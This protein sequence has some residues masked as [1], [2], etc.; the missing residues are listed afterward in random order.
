MNNKPN[1]LIFATK[2]GLAPKG[3]PSAVCYYY[4]QELDK[5]GTQDFSFIPSTEKKQN[6]NLHDLE[7]RYLSKLPEWL[8]GL[9]N[10]LKAIVKYNKMLGGKYPISEFDYAGYDIVHF[11]DVRQLYTRRYELENYKGIV[12]L[13]SHTPQPTGHELFNS[14]P[15]KIRFFIPNLRNRLKEMDRYA[16]E[17]ADYI[18]FP[19]PDA[20]EPYYNDWPEYKEIHDRKIRRYKYVL[21]GIPASTPKRSRNEVFN[22]LS[23]PKENFVISYVGRHNEVKGYDNLKQIGSKFLNANNNTWVVC[24]GK[25][26]SLKRLDHDHWIEIGW[27]TDAHS[28][29]SASD[30]FVL[31][32]KETYFDIVMLEVLSLGKI[33]VAS[34]TGGNKYFEK[35]GCEGVLLY[36]T[37]DEAVNLL[38]KVKNMTIEEREKLGKKNY[39]FYLKHNTVSSMYDSYVETLHEIY[40]EGK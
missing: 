24:A 22:E 17:R 15:A 27:T 40:N 25:E 36:D 2:E 7:K 3:G 14:I 29:I 20:E 34:R 1:C 11:H 5:R 9:Y 6:Q 28:Y 37:I 33:V 10:D 26:E 35:A 16:F 31:P 18:I 19:C 21:T 32:N 8:V 4:S 12:V 23:I 30:V 38:G 39:E 13:Q